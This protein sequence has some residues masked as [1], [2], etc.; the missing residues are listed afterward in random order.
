MDSYRLPP[1]I[2][3]FP[4]TPDYLAKTFVR[5]RGTERVDRARTRAGPVA[6]V[7]IC[8]INR[9]ISVC[10]CAE[11]KESTRPAPVRALFHLV[12]GET[13][14]LA[15]AEGLRHMSIC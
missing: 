15:Q 13:K 9:R 6:L 4:R 2:V 12:Q 11:W 1:A 5:E 3:E 14:S 10:E 8:V 7:G